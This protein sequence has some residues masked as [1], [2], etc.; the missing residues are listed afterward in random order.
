MYTSICI[1][2]CIYMY[3]YVMPNFNIN[4]SQMRKNSKLPKSQ[5][6]QDHAGPRRTDREEK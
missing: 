4:P 2:T 1:Y 5:A 3:I 6:K